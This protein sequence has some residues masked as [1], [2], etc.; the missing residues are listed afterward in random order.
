[1]VD[2]TRKVQTFVVTNHKSSIRVREVLSRICLRKGPS[3]AEATYA[4]YLCVCGVQIDR[5]RCVLPV[6]LVK[7]WKYTRL[8]LA[9][10]TEK[11]FG[12]RYA[13]HPM[14]TTGL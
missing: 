6:P 4:C 9:D 10:L 8:D 1:M 14:Q 11:A 12:T 3:E 7:G 13:I 5:E 2:Q